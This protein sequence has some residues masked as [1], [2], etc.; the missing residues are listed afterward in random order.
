MREIKSKKNNPFKKIF[1]KICRIFGVEL[2]DQSN[3]S[4]PTSNKSIN[5]T[6]SMP[7]K[8]SITL[9][10]GKVDITRPVKSLNIILRTCM[11]VNMLT[12]SKNR[13]FEK[14]KEQYTKRTLISLIKSV[15]CAKDIFKEVKFKIHVIDHNSSKKQINDIKTILER[16]NL[17][18]E[19][20]NLKFKEFSNLIENTNE[21]KKEVT[22]N[23]K[24]NM[25]NIHQSLVLSKEICEDLTYFVE[26]DYIHEKNSLTEMLFTYEKIASLTKKE[27]IICPTDYP[28][29]YSQS[30]GTRIF[31]G[32][33]KHWRQVD[34]TL[35][36][37]LTSKEIIE[38]Y[39]D[40]ITSMCKFEHYPFEKPL[41]NI[42]KKEL[43]ISPIP[44]LAL[45]FTNVNS[46]YGLSPNVDWKRLWDEN[47]N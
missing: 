32:D 31:L 3:F 8:N 20:L 13:I 27:L 42:Y 40:Q 37:F 14:D 2:I 36:T 44:S 6:L 29:L 41:H 39:W 5:E 7:G 24:S 28:F 11:S 4:I 25:S 1:I 43:C 33:K 34:Q 18:F 17:S 23:Q 15:D 16:S 22:N 35:C 26:D 19:I 21:E 45:H 38:R 10:M 46:I 47:S 12:Q 9:P 30:E